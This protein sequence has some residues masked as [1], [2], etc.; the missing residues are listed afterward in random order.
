MGAATV[1]I[2]VS[3][4]HRYMAGVDIPVLQDWLLTLNF[5]LGSGTLHHHV[6]LDGQVWCRLWRAHRHS[7]W[8]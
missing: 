8:R 5:Q 3:V 2:F 6:R 4:M 7:R 1:I